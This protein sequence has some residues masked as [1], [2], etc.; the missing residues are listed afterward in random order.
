MID[1]K[2]IPRIRPEGD[3]GR[4]APPHLRQSCRSQAAEPLGDGEVSQHGLGGE[5][6][7]LSL[8]ANGSDGIVS[9]LRRVPSRQPCLLQLCDVFES[10]APRA[11]GAR[12]QS[13][14]LPHAHPPLRVCL[15]SR[16]RP[17][18]GTCILAIA[19][20]SMLNANTKRI[21]TVF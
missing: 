17:T 8:H 6:C 11:F 18:H 10:G 20:R 2:L 3:G 12:S 15:G 5:L 14:R 7:G 4:A 13:C 19:G 9:D 16:G 21:D 1:G